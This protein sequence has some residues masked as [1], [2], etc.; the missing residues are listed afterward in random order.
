MKKIYLTF[1]VLACIFTSCVNTAEIND[2]PVVEKIIINDVKDTS[3]DYR[4]SVYFKTK[5]SST[6]A[7]MYTDFRYQVG[8]TLISYY[9]FFE[10][11]V[12]PYKDTLNRYRLRIKEL[13][14]I[15]SEQKMYT[16]FLQSKL[17]EI[18]PEEK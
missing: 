9:E 8:D 4:Y 13:E 6:G 11:R 12:K 3:E 18:K 16:Q 15:S 7:V 1:C 5:Y 14:Q 2:N 10:K 17:S